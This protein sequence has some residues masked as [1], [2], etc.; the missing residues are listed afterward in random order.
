MGPAVLSLGRKASESGGET[1]PALE[2]SLSQSVG[3]TLEF[4]ETPPSLISP[5]SNFP[6]TGCHLGAWLLIPRGLAVFGVDKG[7]C[8]LLSAPLQGTWVKPSWTF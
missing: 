6:S 4:S 1:P 8:S 5:A 7:L 2:E 3:S